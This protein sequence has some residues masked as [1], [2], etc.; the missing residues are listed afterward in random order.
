VPLLAMR[1]IRKRFG[2]VE[3][4]KGVDLTLH[5]GEAL[6]LLGENGAGKSTLMKILSGDYS[7]DGGEI[8]LSGTPA[9]IHS[10]RDAENAGIRVIYQELNYAPDLSV[11]KTS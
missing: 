4:L 3:V 7:R 6:A 5:E 1:G 11:A 8:L 10:P 9:Q 2:S